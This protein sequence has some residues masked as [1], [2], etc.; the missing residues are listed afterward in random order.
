MQKIEDAVLAGD[1]EAAGEYL[2]WDSFILRYTLDETVLN[3]DTG[4]T[5]MYFYKPEGDQK[6]YSAPSGITTAAWARAAIHP[7]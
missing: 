4:V 1:L 7:G 2:D 3:Q 6:L 5:S